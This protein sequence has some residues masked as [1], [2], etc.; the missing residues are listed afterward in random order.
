[1]T[2]EP[3]PTSARLVL[4][5][6]RPAACED[7]GA[8]MDCNMMDPSALEGVQDLHRQPPAQLVGGAGV[9]DSGRGAHGRVASPVGCI[10]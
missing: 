7:A 2:S 6:S 9:N 8:T 3:P 10:R 1:M 4:C 5:G